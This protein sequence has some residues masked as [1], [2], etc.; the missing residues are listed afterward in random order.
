[1]TMRQLSSFRSLLQWTAGQ[2]RTFRRQALLNVLLGVL[3]VALNLTLV[4]VTK[5]TIDVATGHTTHIS[6]T[7]GLLLIGGIIVCQVLLAFA[8]RWVRATLGVRTQNKMQARVFEDLLRSDW[9]SLR[10]YHSG[11]VLNRMLKDIN[12][13]VSLLTEDIPAIITTLLQFVGAFLL[14]YY[15]DKHL[16]LMVVVIAP[17][18]IL[19]SK[20]Y[21]RKLR[22]LTHEVRNADSRVQTMLQESV[23]QSLVVKTLERIDYMMLRLEGLHGRLRSSVVH[24]TT[25]SSL[26]AM[27]MS[28]GFGLGYMVA[29][30]WGIYQLQE[31]TSS[32][33]QFLAFVQLVGQL[34]SPVRSLSQYIPVLINATT[35]CERLMEMEQMPKETAHSSHSSCETPQQG[36]GNT[37]PAP[38]AI[39]TLCVE[40]VSYR[41][42]SN[43]R[44][45]LCDFSCQFPPGSITAILGETGAGKTTLLRLLLSLLS[46]QSGRVGFRSPD[47]YFS[48]MTAATRCRLAYVPQGNTLL[49]GTIRD[50]LLLGNPAASEAEMLE[51]LRVAAASFVE[52][53]PQGLDTPCSELGGG[54]SEGQAQR[55]CIARTLLRPSE[56]IIF[57]EST[58][59]LDTKTEVKVIESIIDYCKGRTLIFVT[60]R[61]SVLQYCTQ[62][63]HL[64][65]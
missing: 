41:Y 53:S 17:F 9:S 64:K 26:S 6:L 21:V 58:S 1:M 25:Y 60:H 30:T 19:I 63:L 36:R 11:D 45:I 29:F 43:S 61:P 15:M 50:N 42:T 54:L 62:E 10:R 37:L 23:Q 4:A 16:A 49:S 40:A 12:Q 51:A 3:L 7:G 24:K 47:N 5:W 46:P 35:S 20:L 55:I 59:A 14:L 22:R 32:Y 33:G 44:D 8:Q 2:W 57:D 28:L 27:I 18:F 38:E 34:Q 31:G 39:D 65:R 56:V 48:P 13:L 52:Q